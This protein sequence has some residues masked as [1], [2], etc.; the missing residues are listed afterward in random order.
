MA[1]STTGATAPEASQAVISSAVRQALKHLNASPRADQ[2]EADQDQVLLLRAAPVWRG[3][4]PLRVETPQG[5][6]T[7]LVRG[8]ATVLAVL[9]AI[10][11]DRA[12]GTRLVVLTPCDQEDLGD[13]V[14]AYAVGHEIKPIDRWDL[15]LHAFGARVLDPRLLGRDYRWL[16]EALMDA[17]PGGGWRRA[18]GR[19]LPLDAALGRLA[20]LRLGLDTEDDRLDAAALLDWSRDETR[21]ARFLSLRAEEQAGLAGWLTGSVGAVAEIVFGLLDQGQ[22]ADAIPFGLVTA[23]LY[24]QRHG[25]QDAVM[26]ARGRA[27]QRFFGGRAADPAKLLV[28]REA[29]ESLTLRWNE[30]GH[31]ADA[32]AMCERAEQILAELGARDL[33]EGSLILASGLTARVT[34][35]A[36]AVT[37]ALPTPRPADLPVVEAA[38]SSLHHHR[39]SA[40]QPVEAEA[41]AATRLIR[42]LAADVAQPGSVASCVLDQV[43]ST[44]WVDRALAV[45]ARADTG[46]TPQVASAYAALYEAVRERRAALDENFAA[47]LAGWSAAAGPTQDLLLAENVLERVARPLA[48]LSGLAAPLVVVIDG[49]SAAVACGLAEQ[50]NALRSWE[51]IGRR[52]DGREGAVSVLPSA[53]AYSRT[54]LFCGALRAGGQ[55]EE[56]AGFT[57]FWRGRQ[58]ALIHKAGLPGDPGSRLADPV[59]AAIRDPEVV[60]GVVLNTIDDSLRDDKPGSEPEWRLAQVTYLPELLAE[61]A[62]AGRP[63]LLTADHGHVVQRGEGIKPASAES[64]R[65]RQGTAGQG[66]VQVNGPRVLSPGGTAVLAWD[67]RIRYVPRRAGYHGGASLAEVVVPVLAFVPS[68][69]PVPKGWTRYATSALHEPAWWQPAAGSQSTDAN[70]S[71]SENYAV[72]ES[73]SPRPVGTPGPRSRKPAGGPAGQQP[74]GLFAAEDLTAPASLG[75]RVTASRLYAAQRA[76]VRKAPDDAQVIAVID[77]LAEAGGKLPVTALA[78]AAGQPSFRMAGYLAQLGRLLNVDGYPVIGVTDAGRTAEL[79]RGLIA[80]QFL[81][82][83]R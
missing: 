50:I 71:S 22:V 82:G 45:I 27:E 5:P 59:L 6:V 54:S 53:T 7:A 55:A 10:S 20:A 31:A 26:L 19:V 63:V 8:C 12:K 47:R 21:V 41:E 76:F 60:V 39:R 32:G 25:Q 11:D 73:G 37:A 51:E 74:E 43:R 28:F 15:V 62:F 9:E 78:A 75:R 44:A 29:V 72:A 52:E 16:A 33:A 61:A 80:E 64:A 4:L 46:R 14:L 69:G 2:P 34:A 13:S 35:L 49:M 56:R 68:G 83:G 38:L 79:N 57:A 24:G 81:G 18:S 58:A 70:L 3:D 42:W 66:E 30:N 40:G 36:A 17:Q 48:G 1:A 77:A 65:H 23:E 67:E